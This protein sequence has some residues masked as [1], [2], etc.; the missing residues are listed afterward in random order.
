MTIPRILG[1]ILGIVSAGT[2]VLGAAVDSPTVELTM[3]APWSAPDLLI[4][5]A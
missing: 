1:A 3:I 4:E 2:C 5:I